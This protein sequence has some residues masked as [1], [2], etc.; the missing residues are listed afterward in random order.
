MA[1]WGKPMEQCSG[2]DGWVE[3]NLVNSVY[4]ESWLCR[5]E[6]YEECVESVMSVGT[7]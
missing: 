2:Y 3:K 5:G 4:W 6:Q 1:E 7:M